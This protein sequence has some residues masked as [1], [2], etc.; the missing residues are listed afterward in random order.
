VDTSLPPK[1]LAD[2]EADEVPLLT[3]FALDLGQLVGKDVRQFSERFQQLDQR[4]QYEMIVSEL[5]REGVLPQDPALAEK[6]MKDFYEVFERNAQ[7][8]RE[9]QVTPLEQEI[10]VFQ[11]GERGASGQLGEQ[12]AAWSHGVISHT[13]PG[14]HYTMLKQPS[15]SLLADHLRSSL[16]DVRGRTPIHSPAVQ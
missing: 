3:W 8:V 4:G 12:W 2:K 1:N 14:N 16:R 15:V 9:Y 10:V 11:A 7:A 6:R 5:Q 13:I